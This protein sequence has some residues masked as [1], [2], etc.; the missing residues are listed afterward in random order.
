MCGGGGHPN[1][2]GAY[3]ESILVHVYMYLLYYSNSTTVGQTCS[4]VDL[5]QI[6]QFSVTLT[7]KDC[8]SPSPRYVCVMT[9]F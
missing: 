7:L 5:N 9:C 3:N 8:S 6:A 4:N 1:L 2:Y